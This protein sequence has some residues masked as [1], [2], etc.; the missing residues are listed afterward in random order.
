MPITLAHRLA[1]RLAG[2]EE[3][4]SFIC[5]RMEKPRVTVEYLDDQ[6]KRAISGTVIACQHDESATQEQIR[7]I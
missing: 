5:A 4:K 3:R 6:V 7:R 1:K 2:A